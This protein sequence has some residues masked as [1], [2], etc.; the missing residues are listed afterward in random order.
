MKDTLETFKNPDLSQTWHFKDNTHLES[1]M[2]KLEEKR[3]KLENEKS[4]FK[5]EVKKAAN[6]IKIENERLKQERKFMDIKFKILEDGFIKLTAEQELF[7]KEKKK[8]KK[9]NTNKKYKSYKNQQNDRIHDSDDE[10]ESGIFSDEIFFFKGVTNSLG[11][12]KRYKDLIKIFHP[13]NLF[14][15]NETIVKINYE[16]DKMKE[17]MNYNQKCRK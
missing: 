11:L 15:D 14:G 10:F 6:R 7:E 16:Y 13:D 4:E 5:R 3:K 12:K 17:L 1:E 9:E 2:L 8:Y